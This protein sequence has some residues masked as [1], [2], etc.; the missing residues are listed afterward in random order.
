MVALIVVVTVI[1]FLIVD[2]SLRQITQRMQTAKVSGAHKEALDVPLRLDSTE[3]ARSLKRTAVENPKA[4]IHL[5][6]PSSGESSSRNEFNVPAGVFISSDHTWASIE[7]SGMVRVGIDDFARKLIGHI[8]AIDFPKAGTRVSR[9]EPLFT[10]RQG[11]RKVT[12]PAP[13]SGTI[14]SVNT[15]LTGDTMLIEMK[16]YGQGWV[17]CIEP[18]NLAQDLHALKIGV[19][20]IA[21]Y[22]HEINRFRVLENE[23]S[24]QGK[25]VSGS[26]ETNGSVTTEQMGPKF[27]NAFSRSFLHTPTQ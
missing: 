2:F 26:D 11:S 19:E 23:V 1:V 25:R 24:R 14:A 6:T 21:W 27:W 8:D 5:V 22:R 17:C 15:E 16:P 18:S 20:A 9:G 7:L 12:L 13:V 10:L 4:R 3:K